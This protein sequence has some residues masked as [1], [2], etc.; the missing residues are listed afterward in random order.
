M[1]TYKSTAQLTFQLTLTEPT[2]GDVQTRDINIDTEAGDATTA[3][4]LATTF[5]NNYMAN[6]ANATISGGGTNGSLIQPNYWDDFNVGSEDSAT[7]PAAKPYICT[8]IE[9]WYTE[10]TITY[11]DREPD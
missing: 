7:Q 11:F 10:K 1:A 5:K 4:S 8:G 6:Y 2:S 3:S 9:A